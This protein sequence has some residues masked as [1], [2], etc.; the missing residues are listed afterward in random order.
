[1]LQGRVIRQLREWVARC[2]FKGDVIHGKNCKLIGIAFAALSLVR[3]ARI[4]TKTRQV[5]IFKAL[6]FQIGQSACNSK[7][8]AFLLLA[9]V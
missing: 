8:G 4:I 7:T 2:A 1:M 6:E 9:G 3:K 5:S